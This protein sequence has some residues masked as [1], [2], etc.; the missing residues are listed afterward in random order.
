MNKFYILTFDTNRTDYNYVI[1]H[2]NL[3]GLYPN[4]VKDWW[5]YLHS[6]Y[7]LVSP[8]DVISLYNQIIKCSGDLHFLLVEINPKTYYG[9]LPMDAW[10]W[11]NKYQ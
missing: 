5:H 2:S 10:K 11:L 7:I 8:L 3:V 1:L 9:W 4:V 6:T